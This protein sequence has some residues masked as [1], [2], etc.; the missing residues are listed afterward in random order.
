MQR[1]HAHLFILLTTECLQPVVGSIEI[2]TGIVLALAAA[3]DTDSRGECE[4]YIIILERGITLVVGYDI[5]KGLV[6]VL[7]R[8]PE[9]HQQQRFLV[10]AF[11]LFVFHLGIH[12]IHVLLKVTAT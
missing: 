5:L 11:G 7:P 1:L 6:G 4:I 8:R 9:S 2:L 12:G 10:A 3:V